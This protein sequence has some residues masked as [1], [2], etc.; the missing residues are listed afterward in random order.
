MMFF[1]L[2]C[3]LAKEDYATFQTA[4]RG[5]SAGAMQPCDIFAFLSHVSSEKIL[6]SALRTSVIC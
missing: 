6:R 1:Q 5:A 2:L 3:P 4:R